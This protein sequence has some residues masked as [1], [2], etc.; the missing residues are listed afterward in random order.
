M[1]LIKNGK[2]LTMTGVNYD[3]G[4]VLID[5]G[6]II[7]V[8]ENIDVD[9]SCEII[10]AA[11]FWVM[12]GI[13]E[14][15]CHVG[16]QEEK[17]GF[18]GN[19]CNEMTNPVT[20]YLRALDGINPMDSAFYNALTAGITGI[21]VG[22]G[23][24]NVVGG[25]WMFLKTYGRAIDKMVVLQPSAMKIAFG[26]NPK[27]NYDKK[28][29]M[30][31]TR[32]AIAAM[33]REELFEAQQYYEKR[34]NAE[35]SGD[36]FDKEFRKECWVPVFDKK[37]PLKAHVHRADDILT[38]IRIAK[39][40]N[41]N[42]TLDHCTEG[43]L[44]AKEIKESGFPAIVGPTLTSR[45][46]IETQ[47]AD[48]KTAGILHNEGVKVAITTDHPVTRIQDLLICAGFAAKEGLGIEEGLKAITI[49]PAEICNVSNRV[50]SI[51]VNKDADIAIF[52]GNPMETFTKTMY[53]IINGEIVYS[54]KDKNY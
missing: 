23:S 49:N 38:A 42:L 14:A 17:R 34:K 48:F 37:I 11:G 28:N 4:S 15:H 53:T 8:G 31:S 32:I 29:M 46:K 12:P 35:K 10:D 43:H 44:V 26:E 20:P 21:M 1:L 33:L 54:L 6:K 19:D 7:K 13:I 22:P 18:E 41:L 40:F 27:A 3:S 47:Y 36:S 5:N 39:E 45:N 16:I 24:A 52:D 51:E 2:I 50:G 25:Q 9:E 30:P